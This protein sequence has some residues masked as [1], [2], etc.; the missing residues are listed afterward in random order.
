MIRKKGE[1]SMKKVFAAIVMFF[2][3]VALAGV[4]Y[5]WQGRM[6]GMG[7]PLGLIEDESDFSFIR[8]RSL[9]RD[10]ILS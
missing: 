6:S 10:K 1:E 4:S 2:V 7:K 9:P 8:L 3:V 5:A